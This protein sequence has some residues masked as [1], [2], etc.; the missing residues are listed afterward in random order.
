MPLIRS[1]AF[2][3][4][5]KLISTIILLGEIMPFYSCCVKRRLLYIIIIALSNYQPSSYAKYT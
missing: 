3:C 2:K 5:A 1:L 4:W